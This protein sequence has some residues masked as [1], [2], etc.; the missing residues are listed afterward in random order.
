MRTWEQIKNSHEYE[1]SRRA[2]GF[3]LLA[4]SE[5]CDLDAAI[6]HIAESVLELAENRHE[7]PTL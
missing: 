3:F 1:M 7:V 2:W 6:D 5:D 4:H